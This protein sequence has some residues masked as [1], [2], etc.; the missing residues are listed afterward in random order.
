M[1]I[2]ERI[3][4][5]R[6][7]RGLSQ[8]ELGVAIGYDEKSARARISQYEISNRVPKKETMI[9]IAK[10]LNINLHAISDYTLES[11]TDVMEYLFWLDEKM[12]RKGIALYK[13][14]PA[15]LNLQ[16]LETQSDKPKITIN[17]NNAELNEYLSE[18]FLRKNQ[19]N[20]GDITESEYFEW[21]IG[22]PYK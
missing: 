10:V 2:G 9:L 14:E 7:F 11:S 6:E 19:L 16:I 8:K 3:K 15:I 1:T 13:S 18:W 21:I 5:I 12:N 20:N 22:F 4:I 17:F